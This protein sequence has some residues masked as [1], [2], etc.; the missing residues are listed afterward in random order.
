M[1]EMVDRASSVCVDR[2]RD[3]WLKRVTS[4]EVT[5]Q[6]KKMSRSHLPRVVNHRVY[7]VYCDEFCCLGCRVTGMRVLPRAGTHSSPEA[8]TCGSRIQRSVFNF[9]IKVSGFKDWDVRISP[10]MRL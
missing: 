7:N 9:R 8:R 2:L 5:Q 4:G 6:G 3:G 10:A 1:A